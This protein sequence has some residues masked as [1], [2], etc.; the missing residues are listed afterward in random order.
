MAH[1][2]QLGIQIKSVY[3]WQTVPQPGVCWRKAV[4]GW[5]ARSIH[6]IEMQHRIFA[7]MVAKRR[8]K[9]TLLVRSQHPACDAETV[10]RSG[11]QSKN[12]TWRGDSLF[13]RRRAQE[14]SI[15]SLSG[16]WSFAILQSPSKNP[17]TVTG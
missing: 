14:S 1:Q 17:K 5:A 9:R 6:S 15:F 4:H 16:S 2:L 11:Q 8:Y 13:D 3:L 7:R 10:R 12:G